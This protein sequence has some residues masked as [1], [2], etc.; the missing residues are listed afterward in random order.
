M[1]T[2]LASL[3]P[4]LLTEVPA[5]VELLSKLK[6]DGRTTPTA[7]ELAALGVADGDL[8]AAYGR[9]FPGQPPTGN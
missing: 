8:A 5:A 4:F 1:L 2:L 6:A 9:L 7:D 3:I